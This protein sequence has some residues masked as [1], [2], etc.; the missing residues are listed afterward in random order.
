MSE[1][2]GIDTP[3]GINHRGMDR[4]VLIDILHRVA[5]AGRLGAAGTGIEPRIAEEREGVGQGLRVIHRER[6]ELQRLLAADGERSV[7]FVAQAAKSRP[8]E[9][10]S[11][12]AA[13][14]VRR[15]LALRQPT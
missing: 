11:A 13:V 4:T 6:V 3:V 12:A 2:P 10:L 15:L 1:Y 8:V 14:G 5:Q 7:D 9:G